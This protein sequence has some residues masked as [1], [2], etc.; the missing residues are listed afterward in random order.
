MRAPSFS[1]LKAF[2]VILLVATACTPWPIVADF[3]GMIVLPAFF[4]CVGYFF[5]PDHALRP[6]EY[7]ERRARQL[8]LPF[9]KWAILLLLLHNLWFPLG[10]MKET[11]AI[12][13]S[14]YS[15]HE[16]SQ[17]L[18]SIGLNMSGYD[19]QLAE[20]F[21]M[22]RALLLSNLG[23]LVLFIL[24]RKM[25]RFESD[26]EIGWAIFVISTLLLLWQVQ[27]GLTVTGVAQ[28]GYREL[29]GLFFISSGFLFKQYRAKLE[30]DW[31][32][33]LLCFCLWIPI[34]W[35]YP[36]TMAP[37]ADI[38]H[39]IAL[40]LPAFAGFMLL[41]GTAEVVGKF[42]NV[43]TRLLVYIGENYLCVIA[44]HLLAFKL[45]NML[46]VGIY[47]LPWE[48]VA[49]YPVVQEGQWWDFLW[50]VYLIVG[51]G[52]P[53]LVRHSYLK[54]TEGRRWSFG[55]WGDTLF[56]LL[57]F[58]MVTVLRVL[59][60]IALGIYRFILDFFRA[61]GEFLKASNPKDE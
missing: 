27:G 9:L 44:F 32:T 21:W 45:V 37:E 14:I 46:K 28:G 16:F 23:F 11:S 55:K 40:P 54:L 4:L 8:Y 22:F 12:G 57:L 50:L 34:A 2:A 56:D 61:L 48:R 13:S 17:R 36:V 24:G 43:V 47:G 60:A 38:L 19:E 15:L 3:V 26:K 5:N 33:Y 1:I 58:V 39:F 59:K 29:L 10:L 42:K 49:D 6:A 20:P 52:L 51:V 31:R 41:F 35:F 7:V 30:V 18:W 53:L 25:S